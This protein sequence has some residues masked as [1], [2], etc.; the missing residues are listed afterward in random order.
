MLERAQSVLGRVGAAFGGLL[1]VLRQTMRS[2][3]A[4]RIGEAAAAIAYYALFSLFPLLLA[5]IAVG[6]L[7]LRS[8]RAQSAVVDAVSRG[9]PVAR[10]LV[11]TNVQALIERRGAVGPI[12]TLVLLWSATR[13]FVAVARNVNRA[14]HGAEP[15]GSLQRRL[16]ALAMVGALV[17]LLVLSLLSNVALDILRELGVPVLEVLSTATGRVWRLFSQGAPSLFAFLTLLTL[18]R[19]VPSVH[20]EWS[21]A[22]LGAVA[23]ASAWE[24]ARR[25]FSWYLKSG[26]ARY[27]LVYGSLATVVAL[28]LW[29]YVTGWVVLFGAHLASTVGALPAADG[30]GSVGHAEPAR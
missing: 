20:V 14:W 28:M 17:A 9:L 8:T 19:W 30:E 6:S 2:A 24:V 11:E 16:I 25:A 27:E 13:A 7:F 5:L 29:S 21:S 18:Y 22:A 23:A 26:L 10:S 1:G 12:G 3:R 4:A 15:R